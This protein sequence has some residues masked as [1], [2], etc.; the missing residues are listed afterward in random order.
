MKGNEL[1]SPRLLFAILDWGMGHASRSAPLIAHALAMGWEVHVG[2]KGVA[3]AFLRS[4]FEGEKIVFHKKPGP[5]I[6]YARRGNLLKITR[7]IPSFLRNIRAEENWTNSVVA[8]HGI[9]HI[10]SDN[11]YGVAHFDVP[12]ALISHQLQLPVPLPLKPIAKAFVA[13]QTRKFKAV[14]LPD[15]AECSLSGKLSA[16]S[17]LHHKVPIGVLSRLPAD[18]V[19]GSWKRVGMVSGPEPHRSLME[20]A[21]R[22]W[23]LS[24]SEP[25]LLIAGRPGEDV[26]Q[27]GNLTIWPDPSQAELAS[28]LAG[29]SVIVCR[30]GYSSLLDLAALGKTAV[31]VPT[32]GQPEQLHLAKHWSRQWGMAV[33]SQASLE[34]GAVPRASGRIPAHPPNARAI[35]VLEAFVLGPH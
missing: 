28:A 27:E 26:V 18:T 24:D 3:L 32:P 17:G 11:C 14:W 19:P 22:Q 34:R 9:T 7:Q 25:G 10:V 2:S 23:I 21:L 31:L 13:Q 29:S 1:N 20:E 6:Q 30:S 15:T 33:C 35:A 4:Q 5:A 8:Q 16:A 12:A